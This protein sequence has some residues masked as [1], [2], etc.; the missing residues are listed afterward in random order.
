[1]HVE[2]FRHQVL[3]QGLLA[4]LEQVRLRV[5]VHHGRDHLAYDVREAA[6][7]GKTGQ[8]K[9]RRRRRR[10]RRR[11]GGRGGGAKV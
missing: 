6:R 4:L 10:K 9:E 2:A 7:Q 1:L 8:A 11:R 3:L 5:K